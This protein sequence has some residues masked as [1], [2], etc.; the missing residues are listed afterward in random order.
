MSTRREKPGGRPGWPGD[1]ELRKCEATE[2]K[3]TIQFSSF[4]FVSL[5]YVAISLSR[6]SSMADADALRELLPYNRLRQT[7]YAGGLDVQASHMCVVPHHLR[8]C[9]VSPA[10]LATGGSSSAK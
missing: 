1:G 5:D 10:M 8:C 4:M 2:A 6:T 9:M 7:P 3:A